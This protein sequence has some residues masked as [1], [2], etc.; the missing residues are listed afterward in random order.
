MAENDRTDRVDP[1]DILIFIDIDKA[2]AA[3]ALGIDRADPAGKLV[4]AAADQLGPAR[5]QLT[6]ALVK[7]LRTGNIWVLGHGCTFLG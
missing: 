3:G 5:D 6:G 1:V 7:F 4:G 2:R